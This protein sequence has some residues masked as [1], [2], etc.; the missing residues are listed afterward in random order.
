MKPAL[1]NHRMHGNIPLG[2]GQRSNALEVI[3][4]AYE[5]GPSPLPRSTQARQ[6]SIV[7]ACSAAQTPAASIDGDQWQENQIEVTGGNVLRNGSGGFQDAV[8][9][10]AQRDS[11]REL[12]ELHAPSPVMRDDRKVKAAAACACRT[13]CM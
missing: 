5:L 7:E 10:F 9:V 13:Y 4:N 8:C 2:R 3:S 1:C 6:A 11:R 12:G